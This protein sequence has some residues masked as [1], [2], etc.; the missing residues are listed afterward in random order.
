LEC[1]RSQLQNVQSRVGGTVAMVLM[2]LNLSIAIMLVGL[3]G[4]VH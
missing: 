2:I 1:G 3:L 4:R